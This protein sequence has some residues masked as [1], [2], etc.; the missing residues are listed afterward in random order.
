[1]TG[2]PG[3]QA[4]NTTF[5]RVKSALAPWLK[6]FS[7]FSLPARFLIGATVSAVASAGAVGAITKLGA[8]WFVLYYGV[9]TPADGIPYVAETAAVISVM[10]LTGCALIYIFTYVT[11]VVS[12]SAV[13]HTYRFL[14]G[15]SEKGRIDS[16][17]SHARIPAK[18]ATVV[19]VSAMALAIAKL[20]VPPP[21][22]VLLG[23]FSGSLLLSAILLIDDALV[24]PVKGAIS[25][26]VLLVSASFLLWLPPTYGWFLRTIGH[27]GGRYCTVHLSGE[28]FPRKIEGYLVVRTGTALLMFDGKEQT[29]EIPLEHVLRIEQPTK[30]YWCL[31]GNSGPPKPGDDGFLSR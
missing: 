2:Q 7:T 15:V 13:L 14:K 28:P 1:M 3:E 24:N 11:H 20:P 12:R 4:S 19:L 5:G 6:W 17:R 16:S 22:T 27:G 21:W 23:L 30:V 29:I 18:V 10:L 25:Q 9:R 26:A 31:P 8:Y